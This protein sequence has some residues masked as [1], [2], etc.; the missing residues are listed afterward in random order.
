MPWFR[1][2]ARTGCRHTVA[3]A[4]KEYAHKLLRD[5]KRVHKGLRA[6]AAEPVVNPADRNAEGGAAACLGD[7]AAHCSFSQAAASQ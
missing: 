6:L 2:D 1:P 5:A 4:S 3:G 7:L